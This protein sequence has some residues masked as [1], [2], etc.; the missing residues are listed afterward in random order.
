MGTLD[1]RRDDALVK[2]WLSWSGLD[3]LGL[4]EF[5]A[6]PTREMTLEMMGEL[7]ADIEGERLDTPGIWR[8]GALRLGLLRSANALLG[9]GA[10]ADVLPEHFY[11]SPV[12]DGR[13]AGTVVERADFDRAATVVRTAFGWSK[14]GVE[15]SSQVGADIE[16]VSAQIASRWKEVVS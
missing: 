12:V 11:S 15:P 5:A 4:C 10:E 3:A 14:D 6:P 1:E 13:L 2:L 9:I 16:R 7:V 8:V